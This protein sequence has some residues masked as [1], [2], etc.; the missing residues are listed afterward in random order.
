MSLIVDQRRTTDFD[1]EDDED[2]FYATD[3]KATGLALGRSPRVLLDYS[4]G[5][6]AFALAIADEVGVA[7]EKL[8]SMDNKH[9]DAII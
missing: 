6:Q 9:S 3:S 8:E 5:N 7:F 4:Q 1:V 2:N